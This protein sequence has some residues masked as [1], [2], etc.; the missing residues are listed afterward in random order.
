MQCYPKINPFPRK[1]DGIEVLMIH[2]ADER[3]KNIHVV[4]L[5]PSRKAPN[6]TDCHK[7]A[8][9]THVVKPVGFHRFLKQSVIWIFGRRSTNVLSLQ[10]RRSLRLSTTRSLNLDYRFIDEHSA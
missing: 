8:V 3:L 1:T 5:N 9:N 6:L 2:R 7:Y 10:Q 4:M